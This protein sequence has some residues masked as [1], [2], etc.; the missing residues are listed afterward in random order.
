M[1]H[2]HENVKPDILAVGKGMSGGMMPVSAAFANDNIMM[3][4]KP[5]DHGST[6]GGNPLGM[7]V[8]KVAVET[9][10][11]E[12]MVENSA[13]MGE[14]L[15]DK[16]LSI[17]NPL[18]KDVRGKGLFFSIELKEKKYVDGHDFAESLLKNGIATKATHHYTC[19]FAPALNID[20]KTLLSAC[21]KI[22][23]SL[24]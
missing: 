24:T 22:S 12:G 5:G 23:R 10:I 9:M 18:V 21:A 8:S 15:M 11:E 3:L 7:Y 4:I 6:Y 17:K 16:L 14:I 20:E 13:R 19:R 2:E 1:C